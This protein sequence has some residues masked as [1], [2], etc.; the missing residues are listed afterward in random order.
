MKREFDFAPS[1]LRKAG[2]L[3]QKNPELDPL[4]ETTLERLSKDLSDPRLHT[5]PLSGNLKGKYA[6]SLTNDLRI[7]FKLHN[8]IIHLLDIGPHD[9][10][11]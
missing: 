7:I 3:L 4:Y 2:K 9:Q 10:V 8:D 1:F 11:Y 5:H 6:C